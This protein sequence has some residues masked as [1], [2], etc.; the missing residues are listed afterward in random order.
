MEATRIHSAAG[1]QLPTRGLIDKPPFRSPHHGASP[2]ALVGGGT[3]WMRP[4]E[5]S[6]AAHGVLFLDELGEFSPVALDS[7]RQPLEDGVIRLSRARA[8]VTF[9]ARFL[10]VAAMNPCPCGEAGRPGGC[11]CSDA[12]RMRYRRRLSGPLLD[13]FDLRIEVLAPAVAQLMGTE[14]GESS[15][16]VFE[17][18]AQVRALSA[19]RGVVVNSR[20]SADQLD[21]VAPLT[22]D[23]RRLLIDVLDDGRLSGRGL[24]RVRCVSRTLADLQG[25]EGP[26]LEQHISLALGLRVRPA[27]FQRAL[28]R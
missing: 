2:V 22:H 20:I 11:D 12:T 6:L 17:R 21:D 1:Q 27:A 5:I 10:L 14:P 13:R 18:V 19:E 4:G 3:A 24:H 9:P 23:A 28:V 8:A 7:L 15:A 25:H 16:S 26:I